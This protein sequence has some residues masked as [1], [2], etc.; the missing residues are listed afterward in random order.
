[1]GDVCDA[2]VIDADCVGIGLTTCNL[3]GSCSP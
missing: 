3:D 1:V 2:C